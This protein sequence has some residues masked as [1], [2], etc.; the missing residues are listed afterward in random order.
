MLQILF[1]ISKKIAEN[2]VCQMPEL[3]AASD[4]KMTPSIHS[5]NRKY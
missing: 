5:F 4:I 3:L 1:L 2:A